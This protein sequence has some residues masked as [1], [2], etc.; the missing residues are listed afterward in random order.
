M[1]YIFA[2]LIAINAIIGHFLFQSLTS[3]FLAKKKPQILYLMGMEGDKANQ[4][5]KRG[6]RF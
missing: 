6:Q 1:L 2:I 3:I 4:R 5:S